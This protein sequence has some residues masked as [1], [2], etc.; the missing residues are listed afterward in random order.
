ML[1]QSH[2]AGRLLFINGQ[3]C[4]N[5]LSQLRGPP[6]MKLQLRLQLSCAG[7]IS[8]IVQ[9]WRLQGRGLRFN[10]VEFHTGNSGPGS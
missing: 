2:L 8:H 1:R 4:L 3:Q 6:Q 5:Y 7:G 10:C 9:R